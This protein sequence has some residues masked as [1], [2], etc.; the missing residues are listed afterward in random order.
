MAAR[1]A[2]RSTAGKQTCIGAVQVGSSSIVQKSAQTQTRPVQTNDRV[3]KVNPP[4]M[5]SLGN[6]HQKDYFTGEYARNIYRVCHQA[7]RGHEN[8]SEENVLRTY[9]T[10]VLA[11]PDSCQENLISSTLSGPTSDRED[12]ML[13]SGESSEWPEQLLLGLST[14]ELEDIL[15]SSSEASEY[16]VLIST[17]NQSS[18]RIP[19]ACEERSCNHVIDHRE[20]F[21][22][23]RLPGMVPFGRLV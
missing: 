10:S 7:L 2:M 11:S 6:K 23:F 1:L 18:G 21:R 15:Q 9:C 5:A 12:T 13:P 4:I 8:Q 14:D 19:P 20:G 22:P 16:D 3:T 17:R